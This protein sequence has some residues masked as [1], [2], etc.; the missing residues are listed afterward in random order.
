MKY[1][2]RQPRRARGFAIAVVLYAIALSAMVLVAL[3]TTAARQSSAGREALARV[4]AKWAARAG[5]ETV[6]A[7]LQ[8]ESQQAQPLSAQGLLSALTEDSSAT[9]TGAKYRIAHST[10]DGLID[11]PEDLHAK[12]NVNL[13]TFDDLMLLP[14]MSEDIADAI[15]DWIDADD[16]VRELG[17]ERE[18]YLSMNPSYKPR[19]G[20]IPDLRE[21]EL[22]AGVR[23]EYV[24]GE[25]WNLNGQLDPGEDG[26]AGTTTSNPDGVLDAGW[27][28]FIT[29]GSLDGGV[30]PTG[31]VRTDLT[32]AA[33]TDL[34]AL[35]GVTAIQAQ[36]IS[37]H[38]QAGSGGI[39]DFIRT[40]LNQM[41][42]GQ[43][44]RAQLAAQFGGGGRGGF[45]GGGQN[46]FQIPALTRDQLTALLD[47][48]SMGDAAQLHPGKLN[49]NTCDDTTLDYIATIANNPALKDAILASRDSGGGEL[50]SITDLL[51]V[52]GINR[53]TVADLSRVVDVRSNVFVVTCKG[54]DEATGLSVE[55][56]A[57]L[58][59]STLPVTIR[60]IRFH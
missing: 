9:L 13:M 36:V 59:R 22:V 19:N 10:R 28:A 27:S 49:I 11:G 39:D 56:R 4:R 45:G 14:N 2:S 24:R 16:D 47:K 54:T 34:E 42:E 5:V 6:L 30:S 25:D 43:A 48:C 37:A 35:L 53:A 15:L 1:T 18:T 23:P 12:I 58:D 26:V 57:E 8:F 32:T 21:L 40:D 52:P 3:Q 31:E 55:I 33:S 46:Q 17:A 44:I 7:R 20:P 41:P 60:S 51:D 50:T 29:A 38:A